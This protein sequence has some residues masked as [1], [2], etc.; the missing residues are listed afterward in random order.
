MAAANLEM[1]RSLLQSRKRPTSFGELG[2]SDADEESEKN[3]TPGMSIS[4]VP[5]Q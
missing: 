5:F 3:L 4:H 1:G 2:G